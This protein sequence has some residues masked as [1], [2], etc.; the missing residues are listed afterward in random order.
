MLFYILLPGTGVSY[1]SD[2]RKGTKDLCCQLVQQLA[3][4]NMLLQTH[5]LHLRVLMFQFHLWLP[6]LEAKA[7]MSVF[8]PSLFTTP[9]IHLACQSIF[10]HPW[11]TQLPWTRKGSVRKSS[12]ASQWPG[13][14]MLGQPG[15]HWEGTAWLCASTLA[16]VHISTALTGETVENNI[17]K[18]KTGDVDLPAFIIWQ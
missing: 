11:E 10:P 14:T 15:H 2:L 17:F 13:G 18:D 1:L 16:D 5:T 8:Q 3:H 12:W 7:V 6:C 9:E 4:S